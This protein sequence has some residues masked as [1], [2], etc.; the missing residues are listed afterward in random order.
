MKSVTVL[1]FVAFVLVS[2]SP[3]V[4]GTVM[5]KY[6]REPHIERWV[7]VSYSGGVGGAQYNE[8]YIRRRWYLEIEQV[9]DGVK[10]YKQ[11]EVDSLTFEKAG[12]GDFGEY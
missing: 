9:V 3:V 1:A 12:R 2:C 6:E 11:V 7:G 4:T 10:S 5:G 8:Q